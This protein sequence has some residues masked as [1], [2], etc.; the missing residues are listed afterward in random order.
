LDENRTVRAQD[1]IDGLSAVG[2]NAFT[3]EAA[4][5]TLGGS[6]EAVRAKLRRLK[7]RSR[8]ASPMRS[9]HVV[10]PP[11]YRALGCVPAEHFIDQLM[12][13]LGE[14][15]Y[16]GLLSAAARHGAGHQRP[17]S[18]QVMVP[19][20]RAAI[21]CGQVHVSF[22]ARGDLER[23]PVATFNTPQGYIRYATPELT[24]LELVGYPKHAGGISNVATVLT[25][26]AEVIDGRRLVEAAELCP[27][28]WA[29]R[30]GYL[31]DLVDSGDLAATLEPFVQ[32]HA[33]SY[34]PLRRA[35][36]VAGASRDSRWRVIV[37]VEV[38]P[39]A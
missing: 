1:Y 13:S 6:E 32:T 30:L 28:G 38:E 9:F 39:D 34:I 27:V 25:E 23:V 5:E 18:L 14:P 2:R 31:L 35:Q 19:R 22:I 21:H 15:Y 26:L 33:N 7:Q 10:V 37:N 8:I 16:V 17:Q 24:A 12:L 3:T 20:N 11:E 36:S 4:L 29:Q